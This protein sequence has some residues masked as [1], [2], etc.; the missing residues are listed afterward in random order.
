[1]EVWWGLRVM[2]AHTLLDVYE[3]HDFQTNLPPKLILCPCSYWWQA[4]NASTA[5]ETLLYYQLDDQVLQAAPNPPE[6]F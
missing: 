3:N 4:A 2:L 6:C 5:H 1:M